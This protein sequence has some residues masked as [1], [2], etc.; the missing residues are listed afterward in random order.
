M[1]TSTAAFQ[2]PG[3]L[4]PRR[5]IHVCKNLPWFSKL[6]GGSITQSRGM[7]NIS[8]L[9][10]IRQGIKD[11]FQLPAPA[12]DP[13]AIVIAD[14]PATG[15]GVTT[16]NSAASSSSGVGTT[17]STDTAPAACEPPVPLICDDDDDPL[18]NIAAVALAT[19][20]AAAARKAAKA[21]GNT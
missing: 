7:T 2:C 13:G 10:M 9:N 21:S 3:E 8:I 15:A 19:A 4:L 1:A 14:T 20:Q 11:H 17:S 5:F 18:A 6:I 12:A 16:A